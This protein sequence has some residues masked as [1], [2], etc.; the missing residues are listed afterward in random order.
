[1]PIADV[2]RTRMYANDYGDMR[3]ARSEY[4]RLGDGAA[5]CLSCA[6]HA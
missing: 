5:A 4:R 2:L 1:V 3:L 6:H